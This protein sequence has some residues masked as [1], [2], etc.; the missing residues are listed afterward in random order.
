MNEDLK[1]IQNTLGALRDVQIF[2][3]QLEIPGRECLKM[4]RA[5]GLIENLLAQSEAAESDELMREHLAKKEAAVAEGEK[6]K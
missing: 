4:A 5:L 3:S 6:K 2:L 1:A